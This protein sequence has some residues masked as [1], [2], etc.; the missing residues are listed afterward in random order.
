M[1]GPNQFLSLY[2]CTRDGKYYN[3]FVR[4]KD[5]TD[6]LPI[7]YRFNGFDENGMPSIYIEQTYTDDGNKRSDPNSEKVHVVL[8]DAI[9]NWRLKNAEDVRTSFINRPENLYVQFGSVIR[10]VVQGMF[11]KL[12]DDHMLM[13]SPRY[14]AL[15]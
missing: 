15:A 3:G 6:N 14:S 1:D 9:I 2:F 10:Y 11:F 5:K 12:V 8:E 13:T 7:I 4:R